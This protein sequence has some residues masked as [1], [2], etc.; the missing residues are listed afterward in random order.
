MPKPVL[1]QRRLTTNNC[2][3]ATLPKIAVVRGSGFGEGATM[4]QCGR[5][6]ATWAA[7][8]VLTWNRATCIAFAVLGASTLHAAT[9]TVANSLDSGA[10]SL[11]DAVA[12]ANPGDTINFAPGLSGS[13]ITLTSGEV[14]IDKNLT[15]TGLGAT[16][17]ALSGSN[18]SR[19]FNVSGGTVFIS[20]LTIR[21]G[22]GGNG[23]GGGIYNAGTLSLSSSTVSENSA[24]QLIPG[25][26]CGGVG[27]N[28][29]GIYNAGTL[30]LSDSTISGNGSFG[31]CGGGFGGGI[32][33]HPQGTLTVSKSTLTGNSSALGG[34]IYNDGTVVSGGTVML[35]NSTVSANGAAIP[36]AGGGIF[37][38]SQGP[39]KL[40]LTNTT[41]TNNGALGGSGIASLGTFA[42]AFAGNNN[43]IAG[44]TGSADIDGPFS[45]IHN[46]VGTTANLVLGP[47]A[48]NG[49]PTLTHAL[50]AG[51]V[52]AIGQGDLTTCTTAPVN[53]VDQRGLPRGPI[54]C[55]IGAYEPQNGTP[56]SMPAI[57]ALSNLMLA[58][59]GALL[60][61]CGAQMYR[62]RST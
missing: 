45:G 43:I 21:N 24:F 51:S 41:I 1:R 18:V 2:Y 50:L 31:N 35:S 9:I 60:A 7:W 55:S 23:G 22:L 48:N 61:G 32:Y 28:G 30:I 44:N 14:L 56:P 12:L 62:G 40:I 6:S 47:L 58:L 13:A 38:A 52:A 5:D 27:T 53:G 39:D 49:G 34:G 16:A 19:V 26:F 42:V 59:L 25:S 11:R 17:L 54:A 20:G 29:G 4:A 36:G 15:I 46:I 3:N 8:R 10:G 37:N 57:P 33:N